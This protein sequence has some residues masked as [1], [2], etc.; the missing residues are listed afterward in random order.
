[1]LGRL[2]GPLWWCPPG[3]LGCWEGGRSSSHGRNPC[4]LSCCSIS[5]YGAAGGKG[6]KNTMVRSH[7][8][9]VL[10]IFKL[11]KGDTL[12]VLVGQQGE[13]ACP[14]VSAQSRAFSSYPPGPQRAPPRDPLLPGARI[15]G[16]QLSPCPASKCP[17]VPRAIWG[18]E[19]TGGTAVGVSHPHRDQGQGMGFMNNP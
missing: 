12:Y 17:S 14:S 2:S 1:M 10:G 13:D 16:C 3:L 6:G 19:K 7:G 9:S 5:G 18:H 4:A 8:V 11:E 15:Q